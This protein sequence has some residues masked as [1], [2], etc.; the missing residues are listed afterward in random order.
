LVCHRKQQLLK[1]FLM[2]KI[3]ISTTALALLLI[4]CSSKA[5]TGAL[6]GGAIGAGAGALIGGGQGALIGGAVGVVGG[7]IIG[8]ALDESDRNNLEKNSP[9]TLKKIDR[10][11][12]LS[13]TDIKNMEKNGIKDDVIISQIQAT[14]STYYLTSNQIIDLK[15]SGVSQKVINFMIQTGQQ[16]Y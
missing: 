3:V 9:N 12:Q 5:G 1:E 10:G 15:N 7:A 8:A 16:G 14:K 2:K 11:E 6:A 13:L 4:S